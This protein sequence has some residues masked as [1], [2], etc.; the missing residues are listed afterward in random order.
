MNAEPE[1]EPG[2]QRDP[3]DTL[4][5]VIRVNEMAICTLLEM[6]DEALRVVGWLVK[7]RDRAQEFLSELRVE[8]AKE[9][10]KDRVPCDQQVADPRV[11]GEGKPSA[12]E[13]RGQSAGDPRRIGFLA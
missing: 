13:S 7:A 11:R 8:A 1:P 2:D 6:I 9:K 3:L 12:E 4:N 10:A 5:L